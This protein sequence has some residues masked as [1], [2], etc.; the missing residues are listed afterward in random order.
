V[1]FAEHN[2][3]I[4][5][6]RSTPPK[7][8]AS[9]YE[10]AT[11]TTKHIAIAVD[12]EDTVTCDLKK[13]NQ[14]TGAFYLFRHGET[15]WNAERRLQGQLDI[16]LNHAGRLQ[17]AQSGNTL[18]GLIAADRKA[19][20]HFAFV[21]SPLSRARETMEILRDVLGLPREG[22][23]VELRLAERSFGLWEGLTYPEARALV[24]DRDKWNFAAPQ[25]ESYAQLLVRVRE[26]HASVQGDVI[27]AAHGGVAR[28]LMVLSG[29]WA[30]KDAPEG[31]V[32]Q[33]VVYE[34][35]PGVMKVHGII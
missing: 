15:D 2:S 34:F 33:G 32:E 30:P 1:R 14:T 17:S 28:V 13:A 7:R 23:T 35:G 18:R 12:S 29:V 20:A 3:G 25:G 24:G 31:D 5:N 22:Y 9:E 8:R 16:P 27:V 10:R 26:W 6:R 11:V 4:R 21:S 19:P